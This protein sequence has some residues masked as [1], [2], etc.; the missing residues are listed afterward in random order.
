LSPDG[1][2]HLGTADLRPRLSHNTL[3]AQQ[4]ALDR[5]TINKGTP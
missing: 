3:L 5:E 2:L 4:L 1:F